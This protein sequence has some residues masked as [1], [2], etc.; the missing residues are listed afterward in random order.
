M[1]I[2]STPTRSFFLPLS[3]KSTN[4]PSHPSVNTPVNTPLHSTIDKSFTTPSTT[5]T[6]STITHLE[7]TT[8]TNK[9]VK[10]QETGDASI[11]TYLKSMASHELLR[12]SEEIALARQIRLLL[13][14]EDVREGL[15]GEL[16]RP[17]SYLEWVERINMRRKE[18]DEMDL[19][20]GVEPNFPPLL[21]SVID[22]PTLKKQIRKSKKAKRAM[23]ESNL[24]LVVSIAKRYQHRGLSF[25]DLCQEGTLGLMKATEKF[26]PDKGF[27]LS[28]YA[29]WWI[30][31]SIMRAIADQSRTIRLPVHVHDQLNAIKKTTRELN[32]SLGRAPTDDE[33]A[34]AMNLTVEKLRFLASA[35]KPAISF[36]APKNVG[37]KGSSAGLGGNGAEVTLLD[38]IKDSGP[39]PNDLTESAMLK[40]DVEKLLGTLSDR[41]QQ[42]V[43]MRF[44]LDD[45]KAKTLEEIGNVFSVT[46]ERIRQIEAR[47]LHKLRQPYRNHKLKEY[48]ETA[49]EV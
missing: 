31:Q 23:I 10:V 4:I 42:V 8:S 11:R 49:E 9:K 46:R 5:T 21:P 26:D 43:K 2:A 48:L 47:A 14:W 16:E 17:P 20:E 40:D 44:G 15:E 37:R 29:T 13:E 7:T 36:E 3:Q 35:S 22:V 6:S 33:L 32:N 27:R 39:S 38:S 28:T 19:D 12:A 34:K 25:Q 41:E 30:K 45:G 18:K 24:R 1:L